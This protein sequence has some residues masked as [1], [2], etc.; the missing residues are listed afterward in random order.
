MWH[1]I[2]NLVEIIFLQAYIQGVV[3]SVTWVCL[4]FKVILIFEVAE[5]I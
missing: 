5:Y 4:S 3:V 2:V 1:S